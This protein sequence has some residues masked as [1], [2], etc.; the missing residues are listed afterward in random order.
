MPSTQFIFNKV[1][2]NR[3]QELLNWHRLAE[4]GCAAPIYATFTNGI[5]C[6]YVPGSTLTYE[7]VVDPHIAR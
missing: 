2:Y 6:G 1:F 5:I 3:R 7:S 4:I